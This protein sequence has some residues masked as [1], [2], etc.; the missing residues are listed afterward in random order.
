MAKDCII[1]IE[2]EHVNINIEKLRIEIKNNPEDIS[3][4]KKL[5]DFEKEISN[6]K[7]K[8]NE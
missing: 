5:S 7:D 2:I 6:I 8:Y 4:I 1:R 3:L